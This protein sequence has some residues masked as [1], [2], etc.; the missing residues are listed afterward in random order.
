M[1][2]ALLIAMVAAYMIIGAL[3]ASERATHT[4]QEFNQAGEIPALFDGRD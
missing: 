1:K 2:T 4:Q 3:S